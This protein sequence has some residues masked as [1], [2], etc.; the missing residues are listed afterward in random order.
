MAE[1]E[2]GLLAH[3]GGHPVALG[4]VQRQPFIVIQV[5]DPTGELHRVL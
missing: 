5:R 1:E 4:V 3:R 2:D